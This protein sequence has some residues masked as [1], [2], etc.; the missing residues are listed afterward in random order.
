MATPA[1]QRQYRK[2]NNKRINKVRREHWKRNRKKLLAQNE[3]WR[4]ANKKAIATRIKRRYRTDAKYRKNS[5]R[6]SKE[7]N[8]RKWRTSPK[9][10]RKRFFQHI[11]RK[12]GLT[13]EDYNNLIKKQK[14]RCALCGKIRKLILD[15]D[16]KTGRV[17]GMLCRKCNMWLSVFDDKRKFKKIL[18]Y[19]R[20]NLHE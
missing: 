8:Q 3:K 19:V 20:I 15:H 4:K 12:Y 11:K 10:R 2:K 6:Y 5:Q 9:F 17:R 1:Y 16:H 7:Y 13:P 18:K 14:S